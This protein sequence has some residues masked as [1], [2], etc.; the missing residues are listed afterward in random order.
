M[1]QLLVEWKTMKQRAAYWIIVGMSLAILLIWYVPKHTWK[2]MR[3]PNG[4]TDKLFER[5]LNT[6]T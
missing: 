3:P 6:L 5:L 2:A 4:Q 1:A